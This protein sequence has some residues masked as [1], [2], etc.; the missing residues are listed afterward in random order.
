LN[1]WDVGGQSTLRPFWRNYF[2]KTD[3]LIWVIDASSLD[4]LQEVSKELKQTLDEDRLVGAGLLVW[5]NKMD[6]VVE[7]NEKEL[8][9]KVTQVGIAIT[10]NSF[11]ILF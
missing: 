3:F 8:L 2:E 7:Q 1:I 9:E 4:R 6:I 5:V 11:S 10:C